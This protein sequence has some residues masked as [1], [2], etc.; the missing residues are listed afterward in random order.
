M[1]SNIAH[2]ITWKPD[3]I[4]PEDLK[5]FINAKLVGFVFLDHSNEY[6]RIQF[7]SMFAY[8]TPKNTFSTQAEA[9][10]ALENFIYG[11]IADMANLFI[12]KAAFVAQSR[13]EKI[14]EFLQ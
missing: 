12:D 2:K 9:K 4:D 5:A 10:K 1:G 14:G 11:T 6:Y 3:S 8:V 13:K 7:A